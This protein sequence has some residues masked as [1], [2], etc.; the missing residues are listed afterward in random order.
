MKLAEKMRK[1]LEKDEE[2]IAD[3]QQFVTDKQSEASDREQLRANI[4]ARAYQGAYHALNEYSDYAY[5][6]GN[7]LNATLDSD[8]ANEIIKNANDQYYA[9]LDEKKN[10][11]DIL[12]ILRENLVFR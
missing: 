10:T 5:Q 12:A 3:A 7:Q 9:M 4:A 11:D 1:E 8:W 6:T 2:K